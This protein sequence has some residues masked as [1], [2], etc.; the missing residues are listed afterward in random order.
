MCRNA[1]LQIRK[2]RTSSKNYH[3]YSGK[4]SIQFHKNQY[5]EKRK[6]AATL[7]RKGRAKGRRKDGSAK[8]TERVDRKERKRGRGRGDRRPREGRPGKTFFLTVEPDATRRKNRWYAGTERGKSPAEFEFVGEKR[9]RPEQGPKGQKLQ[10]QAARQ[11]RMRV[12]DLRRRNAT[13]DGGL[14]LRPREGGKRGSSIVLRTKSHNRK[15][16]K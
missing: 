8:S 11:D 1:T 13:P 15:K 6:P 14:Y 2:K 12:Q 10:G 4:Y 5:E 9:S 7:C 16:K 3:G